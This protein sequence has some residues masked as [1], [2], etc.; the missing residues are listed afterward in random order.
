MH[1]E[2]SDILFYNPKTA[3][4]GYQRLPLSLLRLASVLDNRY[5]C[6]FID[7]NLHQ[8]I[9]N[10]P[11]IIEKAR[12]AGSRYLAVSIMPGPQL[13]QAVPDLKRIK[14]SCPDLTIIAGGYF[15]S[16]HWEVC[17][18]HDAIDY[19]VIGPGED[20]FPELLAVLESDPIPEGVLEAVPGL[21]FCRNGEL[22][23]TPDRPMH[24]PDEL[25][26]LPY[27]L[28]NVE[29][30][31]ANTFLGT[32]TLSH[33]SSYGCPF[34][35]NFCAVP[36]LSKGCW[37]GESAQRLGRLAQ[38]LHDRWQIDALEFHDNNFFVN[39]KHVRDFCLELLERN[40]RI[41]WWGEARI[42][43]LLDFSPDTWKLLKQSGLKMVF[44]GAESGDDA[45]LQRMNKGGN[46]NSEMTLE[47]VSLARKHSIIPELSFICGSPPDPGEDIRRV[48]TF[49]R[50]IKKINPQTEIILYRYDPVPA[51]GYMRE[52]IEKTGFKIP[53]TLEGWIDPKWI[54]VHR[55][56]SAD[57]PWL[58]PDD[59][60]L[61]KDFE[62]VL[63]A[64]H[65]TATNRRL[66]TWY[67]KALL[68]G[69]SAW[70]YHSSFYHW[71]GELRLLHK[72]IR[73]QRPETSGF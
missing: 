14:D 32:R 68:R 59:I 21:A 23:K 56:R 15:P 43:T 69:F 63:N 11:V 52:E 60:R 7:G 12:H 30:Y 50:R 40:L 71:P 35:C 47:L 8:K 45:T 20:T 65:P 10:V 19:V 2:T 54:M 34:L 13:Q 18:Q 36:V 46:F 62:T 66:H 39:E 4:P 48:L 57:V 24:H 37:K 25:P 3:K 38:T 29:D 26:D 28:L 55:R 27:D 73:Y 70:R 6:E 5:T 64:Y 9:D 1:Q 17:A 33:V 67:Q 58:R 22:L 72:L 53:T 44:M 49:I 16:L 42:D 31:I 61:V 51:G 41:S